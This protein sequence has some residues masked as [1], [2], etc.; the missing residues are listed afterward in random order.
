LALHHSLIFHYYF[1]TH[2]K[3]FLPKAHFTP[4]RKANKK[5]K[6]RTE[7]KDRCA[8][9][10]NRKATRNMRKLGKMQENGV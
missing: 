10:I 1:W 8:S 7:L 4:E 5:K 3:P 9:A 6:K 2:L